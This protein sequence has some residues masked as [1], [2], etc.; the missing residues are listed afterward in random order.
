MVS[1][2]AVDNYLEPKPEKSHHTHK[3]DSIPDL[4]YILSL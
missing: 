3:N 1:I 4:L 2:P